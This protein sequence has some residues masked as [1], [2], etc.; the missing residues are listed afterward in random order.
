[1]T[2]IGTALVDISALAIDTS[3]ESNLICGYYHVFK[4]Q[5]G[6]ASLDVSMTQ[7]AAKA[8]LGSVKITIRAD[9]NI[10]ECKRMSMQDGTLPKLSYSPTKLPAGYAAEIRR[11]FDDEVLRESMNSMGGV[12][13][14]FHKSQTFGGNLTLGGTLSES[15]GA[16]II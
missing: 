2:L 15:M 4:M 10:G 13:N 6:L 9:N 8:S 14:P 16:G 12:E 3:Q 1:M 7:M 5:D 11:N